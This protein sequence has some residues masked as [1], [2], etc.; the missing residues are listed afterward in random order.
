M[1]NY[2]H[3]ENKRINNPPVGLVS[4]STDNVS[5]SSKYAHDP[6]IDPQLS[7][8]GKVEG[9]SFEVPNVSL[10]IHERIDPQRVA[11]SFIKKRSQPQQQSLF[12]D[13]YNELPLLKA[14]HFYQ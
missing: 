11:K 3:N 4:S 13:P 10:H 2:L 8:A 14:V 12:E 1:E 5:G 7:W 6:H 9:N